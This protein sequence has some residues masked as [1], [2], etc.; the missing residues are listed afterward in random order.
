M[1]IGK[2]KKVI[3]VHSEVQVQCEHIEN[4]Y[5]YNGHNIELSVNYFMM[6]NESVKV[7]RDMKQSAM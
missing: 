5:T 6:W 2:E 1:D 3:R 7:I 4:W